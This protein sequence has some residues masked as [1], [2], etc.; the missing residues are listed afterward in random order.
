MK[1]TIAREPLQ[2]SMQ[3]LVWI[4]GHPF[5]M[6]ALKASAEDYVSLR[7]KDFPDSTYVIQDLNSGS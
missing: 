6:F 2:V 1:V 7:K 3:A 4:D 5:A